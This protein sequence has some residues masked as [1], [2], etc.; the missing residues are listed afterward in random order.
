M[1]AGDGPAAFF[2]FFYFYA[3]F[4]CLFVLRSISLAYGTKAILC[5]IRIPAAAVVSMY[6]TLAVRYGL[7]HAAASRVGF[8]RN[9]QVL[10]AEGC[11][12]ERSRFAFHRSILVETSVF[13][14]PV[15][16][17]KKMCVCVCLLRVLEW[18]VFN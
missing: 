18:N 2:K 12:C 5:S 14:A 16:E 10:F 3:G 7:L 4:L 17:V 15:A 1:L 8:L 9:R 6:R 11:R 13:C